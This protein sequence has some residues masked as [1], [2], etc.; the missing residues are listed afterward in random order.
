MCDTGF[1]LEKSDKKEAEKW[2]LKAIEGNSVRAL[3]NLGLMW[4]NDGKI[5]E[6]LSLIRK[7]AR[8]GH[9]KAVYNLG[10]CYLEGWGVE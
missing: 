10:Q 6:G 7:A 1:L 3:N 5:N 8:Q 4:L 2:Y 9:P